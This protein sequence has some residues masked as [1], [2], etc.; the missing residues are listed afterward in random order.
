MYA[1][2]LLGIGFAVGCVIGGV[3]WGAWR[4]YRDYGW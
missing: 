3:A 2:R 1:L 4:D